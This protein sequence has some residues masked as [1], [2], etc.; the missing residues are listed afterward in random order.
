MDLVPQEVDVVS[1]EVE[2]IEDE[3]DDRV[4]VA[5]DV[6][7]ESKLTKVVLTI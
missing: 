7:D 1:E 2:V 6:E 3:L 5:D 4:V